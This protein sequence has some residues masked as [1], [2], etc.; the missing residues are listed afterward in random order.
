M[1]GGE[2]GGVVIIRGT[3]S[4]VTPDWYKV[5]RRHKSGRNISAVTPLWYKV[6]VGGQYRGGNISAVTPVWYKVSGG[7]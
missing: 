4:A 3:I 7:A 2:G 6:S 1:S 5:S